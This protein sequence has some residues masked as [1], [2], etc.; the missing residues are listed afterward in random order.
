MPD[1]PAPMVAVALLATEYAVLP[2]RKLHGVEFVHPLP[3]VSTC[4]LV[5]WT[6]KSPN[7]E[8]IDAPPPVPPPLCTAT[9]VAL[10]MRP[11]AFTVN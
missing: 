2:K 1:D 6:L 3:M 8:A 9:A 4:G 11:S 7:C 10:V 5:N